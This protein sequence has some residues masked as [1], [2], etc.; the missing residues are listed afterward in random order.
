MISLHCFF[1]FLNI[2]LMSKI[3]TN[4]TLDLSFYKK[5]VYGMPMPFNLTF[6]F[7]KIWHSKTI[8]IWTAKLWELGQLDTLIL[9]QF[10]IGAIWYWANLTLGQFDIGTIWYLNNLTLA[11]FD[12]GTFWHW[13]NLTFENFDIGIWHNLI[14]GQI[15]FGTILQR[16]NLTFGQFCDLHLGNL[17]LG[18][19]D[20][21]W[22]NG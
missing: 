2:L 3:V 21:L 4:L 11:Q 13:H 16:S 15:D 19:L 8:W 7:S 12:I 20:I 17:I 9:G 1:L 14:S 22:P 10:D 6:H 18:Q 5:V